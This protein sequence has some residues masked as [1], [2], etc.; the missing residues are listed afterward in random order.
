MR[1]GMGAI[2]TPG[3]YRIQTALMEASVFTP[4]KMPTDRNAD[5]WIAKL[6]RFP[7]M[8]E[9]GEVWRYDTSITLLG[10][11]I[12]RATGKLLSDVLREHLFE[13]LGMK[14]TG[15]MVPPE[16]LHRFRHA[17]KGIG[18]PARWRSG[19]RQGPAAFLPKC[20]ASQAR[21]GVWSPLPMT[22]SPSPG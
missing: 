13:P 1:M 12:E 14:D 10:A 15:F 17:I 19:I 16:N 18:K 4:F 20:L 9:P 8:D 6:A 21:M 2:M 5:E 7:L 3:N 11:L 22:I